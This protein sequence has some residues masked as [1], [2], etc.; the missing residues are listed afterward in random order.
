[1]K[2]KLLNIFINCVI[3]II[4]ILII[5]TKTLIE[6]NKEVINKIIKLY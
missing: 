3:K 4:D 5:I 2:R 1:M 6:F